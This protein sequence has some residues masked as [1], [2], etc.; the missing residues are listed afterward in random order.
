MFKPV[1]NDPK[2]DSFKK[3]VVKCENAGNLQMLKIQTSLKL[4]LKNIQSRL[5]MTLEKQP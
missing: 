1:F 5:F 4:G 3:I 2:E